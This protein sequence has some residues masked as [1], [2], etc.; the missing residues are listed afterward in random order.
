MCLKKMNL[1]IFPL[2]IRRWIWSSFF[3]LQNIFPVIFDMKKEIIF[4]LVFLVLSLGF[5]YL[6]L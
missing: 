5:L 1:T 2:Q 6:I 4:F 3:F